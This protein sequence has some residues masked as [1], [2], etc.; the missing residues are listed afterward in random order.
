MFEIIEIRECASS[1]FDKIEVAGP[2]FLNFKLTS[3][4]LFSTIEKIEKEGSRFGS[5]ELG[6]N[7][8]IH[9]EFVSANPTGPLH[10]GHGRGAA[11][12]S[13]LSRIYKF[14]GY[15][16]HREYYVNDA[17]RQ[18]DILTISVY[19]RF[20][21]KYLGGSFLLSNDYEGEYVSDI[22]DAIKA[23]GLLDGLVG[24]KFEPTGSNVVELEKAL[25]ESITELKSF[26]SIPVFDAI[27]D[28]SCEYVLNDI[29]ETLEDFRVGFD[30]WFSERSL[31]KDGSIE[32]ALKI[33]DEQKQTYTEKGA[34]WFRASNFGDEKD[35]VLIREGGA[36]TYFASDIGYH[37]RKADDDYSKIVNIWGADH[38]GYIPRLR[39]ALEVLG[40]GNCNLEFM[41]VQF[42]SLVD[43][44]NRK[45][46]MSTRKGSFITLGSLISDVGTDAARFFYLMRKADQHMEFDVS[47]AKEKSTK[48]PVYYVQYA[49][50]RI[51][52]VLAQASELGWSNERDMDNLSTALSTEYEREQILL[53]SQFPDIVMAAA[54]SGEPNI[55]AQYLNDLAHLFHSN[56]AANKM[57]VDD[58]QI[59]NARL[60][61]ASATIKVLANGLE[62]LDISTPKIM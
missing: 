58:M 11:V 28:F 57:L 10:V 26:L 4:A 36:H 29:R 56:Y 15:D 25:D 43:D 61:L 7:K 23:E 53:L 19:Q 22:A 46:S 33:L 13:A 5:N 2:G 40:V 54:N 18:M 45:I 50:A 6:L 21:E 24:K 62:L 31:I 30:C 8:K 47:L 38:H 44:Q 12:G 41:L 34:L 52:S 35:R 1:I 37:A 42:A 48:N 3:E 14:C 9:I 17:G 59:R 16:V 55:I 60:R 51:S 39:A 49:F 27:R 32:N 20:Q